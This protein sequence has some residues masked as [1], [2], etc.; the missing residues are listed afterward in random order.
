MFSQFHAPVFAVEVLI[1]EFLPNPSS[2]SSEWVEFYNTSSTT[3]DLSNY[4]FDDDTNFDSDSGSSPKAALSGL[5]SSLQ[6]CFWELSTYLNN[7]GDS[8]T[9][10]KIG[11]STSVDTYTYSSSSAGLSYARVPDGGNWIVSQQPTQS[12]TK[13]IDLAPSPTPTPS[14]T[15]S[16]TPT[17][18]PAPTAT[19]TP[20]PTST[21]NSPT[22]TPVKSSPNIKPSVTIFPTSVLGESTRSAESRLVETSKLAL[23][24]NLD[25]EKQ[26]SPASAG[27]SFPLIFIILGV[28]FI[29][30]CV[31]LSTWQFRRNKNSTQSE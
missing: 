23:G 11:S 16:P 6:T 27:T 3:I 14:P 21:P 15:S 4:Y 13:C 10:F 26:V 9:I 24:K 7:N 20:T 18:A 12:S 22:L 8:P 2:E 25:N 30:A 19:K 28:V 29:S 1:N 17:S 31:I 5:L